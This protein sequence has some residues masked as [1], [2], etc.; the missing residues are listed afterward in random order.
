MTFNTATLGLDIIIPFAMSSMTT[1]ATNVNAMQDEELQFIALGV[2]IQ[3][4]SPGSPL[5]NLLNIY[6]DGDPKLC[7]F[8]TAFSTI[9]SIFSLPLSTFIYKS[10]LSIT[11]PAEA[12]PYKSMMITSTNYL[13]YICGGACLNRTHPNLAMKIK[14]AGVIGGFFSICIT[15]VLGLFTIPKMLLNLPIGLAKVAIFQPIVGFLLGWVVTK[16]SK[17]WFKSKRITNQTCR[18]V[19]LVC[20]CLNC[21]YNFALFT[22]F[23]SKEKGFFEK[24]IIY[25]LLL[26]FTQL[27]T[28]SIIL[29]FYHVHHKS[30]IQDYSPTDFK[31]RV[32]N[33]NTLAQIE[34]E[35]ADIEEFEEKMLKT[36]L[37]SRRASRTSFNLNLQSMRSTPGPN[38][39]N[40]KFSATS[41]LVNP[42]KRKDSLTS[43]R[44]EK[45]L[46]FKNNLVSTI[47]HIKYPS[48]SS[49][50]PKSIYSTNSVDSSTQRDTSGN[51]SGHNHLLNTKQNENLKLLPDHLKKHLNKSLSKSTVSINRVQHLG[52]EKI[53]KQFINKFKSLGANSA[54]GTARNSIDRRDSSV[55]WSNQADFRK[56]ISHQGSKRNSGVSYGTPDERR[57]A[58]HPQVQPQSSGYQEMDKVL[59]DIRRVS[60]S[61][62]IFNANKMISPPKVRLETDTSRRT[63][64]FSTDVED[65]GQEHVRS[66]LGSAT[67][68]EK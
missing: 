39:N 65:E 2:I 51:V 9:S 41:I 46:R 6:F 48:M 8:L 1:L 3:A 29:L 35:A 47:D 32:R 12:T 17:W 7:L 58:I 15:G 13:I 50:R 18:T 5:T 19:A 43:I 42:N 63:L 60:K 14:I 25:P 23:Y 28:I 62:D 31:N 40:R 44:T 24:T 38:Q 54:I 45:S 66:R 36:N 59:D 26:A 68:S 52:N 4:S 56:M 11:I 27:V 16:F 34:K 53:Q 30:K 33:L 20:S 37:N 57:Y 55:L 10:I 61:K 67:Q 49:I 64:Y 22:N 21:Q